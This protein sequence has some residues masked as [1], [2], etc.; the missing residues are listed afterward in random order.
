[1]GATTDFDELARRYDA[2]YARPIGTWA[3]RYE[4]AAVFRLLA[5]APGERVLDL[6]VGTG[7]YA[8]SVARTGAWVVG[9]DGAAGMLA[10]ARSRTDVDTVVLVRADAARLPFRDGAFDAVLAVTSLCFTADPGRVLTEAARVLRPG[11]RLV[12]GELNRWS[13]WALLRRVEGLFR[14]TTYRPAHFRG[15]RELRA[16][17]VTA[18]LVPVRW[19]GLLHLPPLDHAGFLRALDPLERLAQRRCPTVGAF[20]AV[21]A[22]RP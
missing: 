10:V 2:W 17:L 12:L 16:L 7:R 9:V 18:G 15:I 3:D 22:Q 11:G 13:L 1:M 5:P 14:P 21:K 19:E 20:L 4:T 8:A 6:G